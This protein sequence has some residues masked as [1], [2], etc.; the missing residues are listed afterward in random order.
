ML[1]HISGPAD[2]SLRE[3]RQAAEEIRATADPRANVIF[4]A[5]IGEVPDGEVHIT[6]IATGLDSHRTGRTAAATDAD[7]P[8][9]TGSPARA[10]RRCSGESRAG[11]SHCPSRSGDGYLEA[12][13]TA[14]GACHARPGGGDDH[15]RHRPPARAR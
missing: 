9:D 12:R 11:D 6:L 15:S 10:V 3:V 8:P 2:L 14:I 4:G 1:L 13:H 7:R 5:S